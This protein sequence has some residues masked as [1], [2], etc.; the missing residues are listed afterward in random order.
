MDSIEVGEELEVAR[1]HRGE[2]GHLQPCRHN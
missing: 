1:G 2:K